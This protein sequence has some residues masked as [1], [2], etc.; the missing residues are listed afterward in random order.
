M[1]ERE[2]VCD[3]L[4]KTL[5]T[6]T[7]CLIVVNLT[8]VLSPAVLVG[9]VSKAQ[10]DSLLYLSLSFSE[11]GFLVITLPPLPHTHTPH[12]PPSVLHVVFIEELRAAGPNI[13]LFRLFLRC[14]SLLFWVMWS[15]PRGYERWYPQHPTISPPKIFTTETSSTPPQHFNPPPNAL[16]ALYHRR[17]HG[18]K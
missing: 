4:L 3:T 2:S 1:S 11:A 14:L 17:K 6:H 7:H 5:H 16:T 15:P 10:R 8:T 18:I 9:N 12:P 13:S